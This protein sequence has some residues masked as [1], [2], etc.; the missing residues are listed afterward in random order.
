MWATKL[1]LSFLWVHEL[2]NQ[3]KQEPDEATRNALFKELLDIHKEHPYM[4]GTVGED[5]VPVVVKNNFFNVGSGF[6]YDDALRSQGICV[7]AQLFM[8]A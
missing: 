4:I 6:A 7:P 8:R 2:W 5:P 1:A 3:T